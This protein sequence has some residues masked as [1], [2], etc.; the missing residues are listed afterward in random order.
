[1]IQAIHL[2]GSEWLESDTDA[3]TIYSRW[4]TLYTVA[5]KHTSHEHTQ[6]H[7]VYIT[8]PHWSTH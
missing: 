4:Y 6:L 8:S 3:A 5:V 2:A 1:M 7:T